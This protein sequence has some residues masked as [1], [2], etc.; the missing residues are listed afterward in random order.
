MSRT[1]LVVTTC[2]IVLGIYDLWTVAV[3]GVESSVSRF[4][5]D[6]GFSNPTIVFTIGYI[7][8][9]VFGYMPPKKEKGV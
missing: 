7:C 6:A 1:A 3:G 9:H 5:Q 4:M 2:V 8:G